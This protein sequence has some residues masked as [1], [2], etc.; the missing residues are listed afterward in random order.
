MYLLCLNALRVLPRTLTGPLRRRV[1]KDPSSRHGCAVPEAAVEGTRGLDGRGHLAV[2]KCVSTAPLNYSTVYR[3]VG[4]CLVASAVARD[5]Q[6]ERLIGAG[7]L[8]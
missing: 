1:T 4:R 8:S 3:D 5:C 2:P 7:K 6:V